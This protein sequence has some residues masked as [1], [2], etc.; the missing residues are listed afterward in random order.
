MA[1]SIAVGSPPE[2]KLD[3]TTRAI[4]TSG[5]INNAAALTPKSKPAKKHGLLNPSS[6]TD[7]SQPS[8]AATCKAAAATKNGN[9][10]SPA[11]TA[12]S[13]ANNAKRRKILLDSNTPAKKLS[14]P[15]NLIISAAVRM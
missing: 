2:I 4:P 8:I 15:R 5:C 9:N 6:D 1:Q 7:A 12:T 13:V 11:T 10:P 3:N 14:F